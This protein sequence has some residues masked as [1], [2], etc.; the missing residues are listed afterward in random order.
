MTATTNTGDVLLAAEGVTVLEARSE[1][2]DKGPRVE[3]VAYSGNL[4]VVPLWGTVGLDLSGLDVSGQVPLLADH[5]A[6]VGGV[7][8]HGEARIA[9]G[10]LLVTGVLSGAGEAARQVVELARRGFAFQASVG[11]EVVEHERVGPNRKAEVNGRVLS[12]PRGF[13][14][15]RRGRLREVSITPL[16]ADADTRVSIA[17]SAAGGRK[18]M[19]TDAMSVE[20][21]AIRADERERVRRI[22]TL[23]AAP[24][25]GWGE[26]Q[27][28]VEELK[29]AA[30]AGDI[31]EQDLSGQLL[32][33][34]RESRPKWFPPSRSS[35]RAVG[36]ATL[37]EAALL[38]HMGLGELGEKTLGPLA[39]EHGAALGATHALDLC[40]AALAYECRDVPRGR[41][42]LVRAALSTVS[43]PTALGNVAN[44]LLLDSYNEVPASWKSFCSLRSVAD[45]KPNTA[46]RPSF[47]TPLEPVAPGGEL[48][49]GTVGESVTTFKADTF[50]K[51]LSIDRRDLI[52]DDL[53][54]F[55]TTAQAL[56]RAAM[57]KVS[58]LV[59]EVLL[60]NEGDFF[61]EG[62]GNYLSGANSAL[63]FDSLAA[64]ITLMRSQRDAEGNDLDLKPATLLVPPGLETVARAL[65]NSE[66][67]QRAVDVPTGNSL[68]Q[69]VNLEV[70]PRLA[71]T[72]KFGAAASSKH[73]YLFAAPSAN[74]MIVAFL[75]GRQSPTVEA[76]GL[77]HDVERLA[78]SWRCYHDFGTA[79]VDARAAVR[80]KGQA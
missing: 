4:M 78:F 36:Q 8:G 1:T 58:D 27:P 76:F 13:M 80:S 16:G 5:D 12:S 25:G 32:T 74:A 50:G 66:F 22:E 7:V 67:I 24:G 53:G 40:R 55:T 48:K 60:G 70:E 57:R 19:S 73:W 77:D 61:S 29:A 39:M 37:L 21:Q 63:S 47:M 28:R 30:L 23:C 38:G 45:F 41:E 62:N 59:Y 71:N 26:N 68:R 69:A 33:I 10:R 31:T 75:D 51:M 17:A 34:L 43:L 65:L 72:A 46:I 18:D 3:V 2:A 14:L 56:G 6:G 11:V 49:H 15:V 20:E 35:S 9:D 44:K 42:E 52:N 64:A 79:L 54:L